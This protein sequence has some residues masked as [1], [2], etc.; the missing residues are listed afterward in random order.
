MNSTKL[1]AGMVQC[2]TIGGPLRAR[3]FKIE[4]L[5]GPR[6]LLQSYN[7]DGTPEKFRYPGD[8]DWRNS[9]VHRANIIEQ[10]NPNL[11]PGWEDRTEAI[12]EK[13]IAEA[14]ALAEV[15]KVKKS[16]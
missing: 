6:R 7:S 5:T 3:L 11:A 14:V 1:P 12:R 8:F 9:L 4:D 13:I 16:P 15:S 2:S 10:G